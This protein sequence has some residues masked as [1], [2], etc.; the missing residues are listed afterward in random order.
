[1][2]LHHA[3]RP[4]GQ[5]KVMVHWPSAALIRMRMASDTAISAV[6]VDMAASVATFRRPVVTLNPVDATAALLQSFG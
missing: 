2:V 6:S 4:F 5:S 3:G 1:M